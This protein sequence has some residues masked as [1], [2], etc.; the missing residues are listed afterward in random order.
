MPLPLLKMQQS[1]NILEKKN[2][3]NIT[4]GGFAIDIFSWEDI[5]D[6]LKEHRLT[7]NWYINN[8]QYADNSDVNISISLDDDDDALHPEYFRITQK[9]KLR[10][11][12]YTED[13]WAS[14][15][16]PVSIFNQTSNVD[17][18]WCD[19]YF[20]VSNIGSTTIDDYKI[21]IQIDNCQKLSCKVNYCNN[22]L[23]NQAVVASINDKIDRERELFETQ[24]CNVL[25]FRPQ[26]TRLL[27]NDFDN[28]TIGVKPEDNVEEIIV[29]W[30]LLS[31]DYQKDGKLTIPVKP[32]FEDNE[33]IIYVDTPDELKPNEEIIEPK[34]VEE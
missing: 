14:I 13:I 4:N 2:V 29:Q 1:K 17:Y 25:E 31:R 8:C 22:Y 12:N 33:R 11:R 23:M 28:F 27:K 15:I 30:K 32:R 26:Q 9:Y 20:E 10:E 6:L 19:I 24:W 18:R 34:I 3:E 7:Y 21:Y 5:V 16:P